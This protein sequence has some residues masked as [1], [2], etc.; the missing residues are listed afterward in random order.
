MT[1]FS[2]VILICLLSI[3]TGQCRPSS[4]SSSYSP[5]H[6]SSS[7]PSSIQSST[8]RHHNNRHKHAT[9]GPD[10]LDVETIQQLRPCF[11]NEET[12][13]LCQRCAKESK[14]KNVFPLCC[15]NVDGVKNW[16]EEYI[17]YGLK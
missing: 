15:S 10:E 11:D 12:M 4:S 3:N 8:I 9:E 6:Y 2:T 17:Y 16:C 13:E 7:T 1:I 14:A 5:H